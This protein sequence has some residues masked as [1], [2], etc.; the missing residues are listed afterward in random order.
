ME[1]EY[2]NNIFENLQGQFDTEEPQVGHQDR[3]LSRLNQQSLAQEEP[4]T[5]FWKPWMSIAA[6]FLLVAMVF[7][8]FQNNDT[9]RDLASIS[10]EME[11]T[12][13]F[14]TTAINAELAKLEAEQSPEFQDMI[15]DA[16][17]QIELLEQDY[18]RMR[19]DLEASGDDKRVIHAMITNFQNRIDILENVMNQINELKNNN[20]FNNENSTT[21]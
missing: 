1:K 3:F 14:F 15:V 7:I 19:D 10:P 8:G 20:E 13:T 17:F 4:R 16:L 18:Q 9:K 21:L 6:S 12:Q 2:L 11:T 5:S